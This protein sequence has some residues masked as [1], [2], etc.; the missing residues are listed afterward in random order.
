MKVIEI[1]FEK[2]RAGYLTYLFDTGQ[3]PNKY[4]PALLQIKIDHPEWNLKKLRSNVENR[5]LRPK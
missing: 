4:I 2:W 5:T 3:L 1:N